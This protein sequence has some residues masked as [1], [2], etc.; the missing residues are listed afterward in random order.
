MDLEREKKEDPVYNPEDCPEGLI[1]ISSSSNALMRPH[2]ERWVD[3]SLTQLNR[4]VKE[5]LG[6]S[7]TAGSLALR[8]AIAAYTNANFYP[9]P[10]I[11]PGSIIVGN[12]ITSLLSTL[13]YSLC[14]YKEG[15]MVETPNYAS[16]DRLVQAYA[17]AYAN[18]S[19]QGT[20]VR[21]IIISNPC[22][23]VGRCYSRETLIK[24]AQFCSSKKLHLISDEIYALSAAPGTHGLDGFTSALSL[25]CQEAGDPSG[26]HVV[27]G[28]S[29]D[30]GL[31]GLRLGWII[32]RNPSVW[33]ATRRLG[34]TTWVS[35]FSDRLFT[36]LLCDDAFLENYKTDLVRTLDK[37]RQRAM[38]C[39]GDIG[40]PFERAN[41]GLF[42]YIDL[43][44]WVSKFRSETAVKGKGVAELDLCRSL[45][46]HGIFLQPDM[47]FLSQN[48]GKFRLVHTANSMDVFDTA[49]G[50]LKRCLSDLNS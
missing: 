9:N 47:A 16:S 39:L 6:H 3:S 35:S 46:Q 13:S 27:S 30:F 50:K 2:V 7:A 24:L 17:E 5:S 12:G 48:T 36:K 43:S 14:D 32:T 37:S 18:A 4:D 19:E 38:E 26:I 29:K 20:I 41:S 8:Q 21:A 44:E 25:S 23:P 33:K 10:L 34:P 22:N 40:I 45:M 31:A 11:A 15:V 28:A 1:N 42:L 49:M